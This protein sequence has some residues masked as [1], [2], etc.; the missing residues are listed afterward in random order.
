MPVILTPGSFDAWLDG[1]SGTGDARALLAP[2]D[3]ELTL[4]PV[5]RRVND[6]GNDDPGCVVPTGET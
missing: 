3:G 1:V 4:G 6:V 2:Y 5:G